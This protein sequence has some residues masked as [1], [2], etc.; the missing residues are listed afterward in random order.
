M[1]IRVTGQ[2]GRAA[3]RAAGGV[4]SGS[5]NLPRGGRG[6]APPSGREYLL[7]RIK[8]AASNREIRGF[9]P[10]R[11]AVARWVRDERVEHHAGVTT[12]YHL[13]PRSSVAGY[14]DAVQAA[15]PA[16]GLRAIVS[17]PWPP[18]AFASPD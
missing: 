9:E 4:R 2:S 8:A 6:S 13:I 16:A 3:S 10:I 15:A 12:V 1:T 14:R 17:G 11:Q 7:A 5:R 18:Y